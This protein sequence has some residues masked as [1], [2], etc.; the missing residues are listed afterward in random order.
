M[1]VLD[2]YPREELFQIPDDQLLEFAT[3]IA[4]LTDRPR[5]RVLPRID[6]FD[7]F[8][9]ILVYVPRD[10]YDSDI[11]VRIGAYLAEVYEGRVSA[12]YPS[13]PEG[14]LVRVQ[15]IIGRNGGT[16]AAPVA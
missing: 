4:N 1:N 11:R 8:V 3:I 12:F 15:F 9:S 7:N 10:R 6:R 2:T 16:H 14:D 13:F 5:V